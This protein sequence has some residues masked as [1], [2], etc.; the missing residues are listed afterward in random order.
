MKKSGNMF[1]TSTVRKAADGDI[2]MLFGQCN[3]GHM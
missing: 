3:K 2:R 1:V